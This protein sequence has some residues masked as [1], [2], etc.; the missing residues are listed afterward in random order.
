MVVVA[1]LVLVLLEKEEEEEMAGR[2]QFM[3]EEEWEAME[4]Q[5]AGIERKAPA[6]WI[7]G[8]AE[9]EQQKR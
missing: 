7:G 6:R 2:A 1:V 3:L 5:G 4:G 9:E 8:G